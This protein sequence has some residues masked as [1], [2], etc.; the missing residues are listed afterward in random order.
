MAIAPI[1]ERRLFHEI[2]QYV[3]RNRRFLNM[4]SNKPYVIGSLQEHASKMKDC[5]TALTEA[6]GK[7]G[8][9]VPVLVTP[10][11]TS[12]YQQSTDTI[13]QNTETTETQLK[14]DG[15][16][17]QTLT[18]WLVAFRVKHGLLLGKEKDLKISEGLCGLNILD[19]LRKSNQ[20]FLLLKMLKEYF[21]TIT[22]TALKKYVY[23]SV[24]S[25][26]QLTLRF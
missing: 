8:G 4:E 22:E 17:Y 15:K 11:S 9:H 19:A 20:H 23:A 14:L 18:S 5:S 2:F 12:G 1:K 10:K 13:I 7:G 26:M 25:D 24:N 21:P 3:F 16:M 6:M